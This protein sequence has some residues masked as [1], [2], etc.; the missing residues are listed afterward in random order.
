MRNRSHRL[1]KPYRSTRAILEFARAFYQRRQPDDDEPLNLPSNEFDQLNAQL[2]AGSAALMKD[3]NTYEFS[4][5]VVGASDH[6]SSSTTED[7][8]LR[9][10]LIIRANSC[11][12]WSKPTAAMTPRSSDDAFV[13]L[14]HV[15]KVQ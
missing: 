9:N 14:V 2:G 3:P 12:S 1:E 4:T 15:L 7:A 5:G 8:G 11:D 6:L 10:P 13:P